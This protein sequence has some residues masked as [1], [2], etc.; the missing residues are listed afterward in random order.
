MMKIYRRFR[1]FSFISAKPGN[2]GGSAIPSVRQRVRAETGKAA[3]H[4]A[5]FD[6]FI[7]GHREQCA[8]AAVR[9]SYRTDSLAVHLWQRHEVINR[10]HRVIAHLRHDAAARVA[11]VNAN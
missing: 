5:R 3:T 11:L 1:H 8:V 10:A 9:M 4:Y 2:Q 7:K 6:S